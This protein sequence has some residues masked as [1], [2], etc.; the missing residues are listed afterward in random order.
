MI[1]TAVAGDLP[2]ILEI[3][4]DSTSAAHWSELEY[5]K[6]ISSVVNRLVLIA[7]RESQIVGFLVASTAT[8][9]WELENIAVSPSERQRGVGRELLMSLIERA[10]QAKA[11]EIRQEIRASNLA[12][13]RLGQCVGFVQEGR[14]RNYYRDPAEDAL[15]FK[16][17]VARP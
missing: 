12:A 8:S 13:H 14:R 7:E 5:A 17:L 3:E 16:Y 6:A 4:R 15:L 11:T 10:Q 2:K 9:E 1:R